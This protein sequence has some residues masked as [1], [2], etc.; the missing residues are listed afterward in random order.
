[1]TTTPANIN[2]PQRGNRL[3][4]GFGQFFL[5]LLGWSFDNRLPD[6][7]KQ[8]IIVAPHTSNW[9]FIIGILAVFA[10]GIEAHWIGKHTLFFPPLNFLMEWL[11]GISVNRSLP[12]DLIK[13]TA[14][15]FNREEKFIIGIAPEGTRRKVE[16][17]KRGYYL[18][19]SNA[20]VPITC[21][22]LDYRSRTIGFGK[23]LM[24]TGD[25]DADFKIISQFFSTVTGKYPDNF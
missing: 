14:E 2:L 22:S 7:P 13:T 3:T 16:N 12:N 19:A 15:R 11:G 9:D 10:L 8:V 18:I 21:A 20:G 1:L 17:W 23:P 4:R 25:Y 24:P 6:L 5:D